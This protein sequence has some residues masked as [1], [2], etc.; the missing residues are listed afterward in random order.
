MS[1]INPNHPMT[2]AVHDQWH[3]LCA[4][5]VQKLADGHA[6]ITLRDLQLMSP[7]TCITVQETIHGIELRLVTEEEGMRLARQQGGLPQ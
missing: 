2:A 5:L 7:G 3:K 6:V 1:E 4:V